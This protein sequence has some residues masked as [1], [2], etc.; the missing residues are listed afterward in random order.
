MNSAEIKFNKLFK[1]NQISGNKDTAA[2]WRRLNMQSGVYQPVPLFATVAELAPE[3][4]ADGFGAKTFSGLAEN[5]PENVNIITLEE[6]LGMEGQALLIRLE[7]TFAPDEDEEL[8]KP[9]ELKLMEIFADIEFVEAVELTLGGN[10]ALENMERLHWN[11]EGMD[12]DQ[13]EATHP[14]AT[15]FDGNSVTLEP[16]QIRTFKLDLYEIPGTT[17]TTA[18]TGTE[19][20]SEPGSATFNSVSFHAMSIVLMAHKVL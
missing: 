7:H 6:K 17:T 1:I 5:L 3:D 16:M 4:W 14:M 15:D 20:T 8:S 13:H 18:T 2:R 19:D 12:N 10:M 11:T 9:V